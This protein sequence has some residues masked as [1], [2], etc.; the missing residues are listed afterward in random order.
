[1]SQPDVLSFPSRA[2]K[3][4]KGQSGHGVKEALKR[5][6]DG[7]PKGGEAVLTQ[8]RDL[9]VGPHQRLSEARFEELLDILD[10]QDTF[11]RGKFAEIEAGLDD[12]SA[13]AAD[14]RG[15]YDTL[16]NR[17]ETLWCSR[18]KPKRR[19]RGWPS[20]KPWASCVTSLT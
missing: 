19:P 2:L 12:V 18:R 3:K 4:V 7:H 15:K 1:M 9:L 17:I 8:L 20:R 5:N 6:P 14:L 10:E 11:N 13:E 16:S